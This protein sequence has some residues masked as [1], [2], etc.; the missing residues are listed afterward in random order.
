MNPDPEPHRFLS[1]EECQTLSQQLIGMSVGGGLTSLRVDTQWR[2][3]LRWGRNA[4]TTGGETQFSNVTITRTIHGASSST[5]V[6]NSLDPAVLEAMLRRTEHTVLWRSED[7]DRYPSPPPDIHPYA[8]PKI[9]FDDTYNVTTPMR[10]QIAADVIKRAKAGGM[11][12][13]GYI[14]VEA[15]GNMVSDSNKMFRYYPFTK[16]QYSLTV[17]DVHGAGSGWAG[18]DWDDWKR[19]DTQH[20]AD[21][22]F[23]KCQQSRNPVAVEPGRYTAILEPQA[24]CDLFAPIMDQALSRIM[25]E[26]G[27]GPFADRPGFS[28]IGQRLFD[29]RFTVTADPE[30][31]DCGFVPFDWGGEPYLKTAWIDKGVLKELEYPRFYGLQQMGKDWA[32][33]N[34]R[35]FRISGGT[36]TIDDM[37]ASTRRG[38][39]V[40]RF[41]SVRVVDFQSML[42]DG[43]T[44]DGLWL[45]EKGKISKAAKN[46]HFT[47]SPMF[48]FNNIEEFGVP[49]RVF[50][51]DAPAV[52]PA[53]KVRD[54]SFTG[55]VDAV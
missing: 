2:G 16:A 19:I 29:E 40:T 34:S 41:S 24:V 5:E 52:C 6:T 32:L 53:L 3:D 26:N 11:T 13:A 43:N 7:P 54:F 27:R 8:K 21:V 46:F 17:R 22:A 35:A 36:T 31:L 51:P 38:F 1:Q 15:E 23:E 20:L 12:V 25:A 47:E 37:I 10:G 44:R 18:V 48:A 39:L 50:R 14:A 42:L 49:Q 4:V 30:D 28:K 33:P 9:W 45:I 55:L